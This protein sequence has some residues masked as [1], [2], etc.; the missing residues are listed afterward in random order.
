MLGKTLAK[1]DRFYPILGVV[2]I[3]LSILVIFSLKS[4]LF[5]IV[6]AS[7]FDPDI[8]EAKTRIDSDNLIKAH[9]A[10]FEKEVLRLNLAQ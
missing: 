7:E 2:L 9:K 10:A 5:G 3:A 6:L 1:I 8:A 4:V